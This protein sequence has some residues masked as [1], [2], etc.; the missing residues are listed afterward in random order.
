MSNGPLHAGW[1]ITG[2]GLALTLSPMASAVAQDGVPE[3]GEKLTLIAPLKPAEFESFEELGQVLRKSL[4]ISYESKDSRSIEVLLMSVLV[5]PDGDVL[6]QCTSGLTSVVPGRRTAL[7]DVCE[8][9][10]YGGI[11]DGS[12]IRGLEP[13]T[14]ELGEAIILDHE[15]REGTD[16]KNPRALLIQ[17]ATE[18]ARRLNVP[19]LAIGVS[20]A[21]AEAGR[22]GQ[23][24]YV[25]WP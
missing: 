25:G 22:L 8:D 1:L 21:D 23:S 10:R 13:S 18:A 3:S 24:F 4:S 12:G 17:L 9:R 5:S 2:L 14:V 15:E 19:I 20:P 11:L 6:S 7:P 16:A